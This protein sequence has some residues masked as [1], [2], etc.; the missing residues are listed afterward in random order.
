MDFKIKLELKNWNIH[1][2]NSTLYA[3]RPDSRWCWSTRFT[4]HNTWPYS[5]HI[6]PRTNPDD[7]PTNRPDSP[8][9]ILDHIRH[10]YHP[11]QIQMTPLPIEQI[12]PSQYLTILITH[13]FRTNPDN[14]LAIDKIHP[15]Q[16]LTIFT[17]YTIQNLSRLYWHR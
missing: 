5:S 4:H 15:S 2:M 14:T 9:T 17:T 7:T 1:Y 13:S 6:P 10:T 11:E 12:H 3:E 16:Y 8:F